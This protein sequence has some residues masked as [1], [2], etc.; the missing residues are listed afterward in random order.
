M[1]ASIINSNYD[2]I[3]NC[4][5]LTENKGFILLSDAG[6]MVG[7]IGSHG[8]FM[9][10]NFRLHHPYDPYHPYQMNNNWLYYPVYNPRPLSLGKHRKDGKDGVIKNVW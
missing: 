10:R 3:Y 2:D 7:I 1:T 8:R 6:W 9:S 4:C 5:C